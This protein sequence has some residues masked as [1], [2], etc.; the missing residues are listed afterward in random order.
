VSSFSSHAVLGMRVDSVELADAVRIVL[1]WSESVHSSSTATGRGRY[2]CAANVHM[3]MEAYDHEDFRQDVNASD[4]VV[5]DGQPVVWALRFQRVPQQRRVRVSPDWLLQVLAGAQARSLKIGLYGGDPQ[6]LRTFSERLKR[7]FPALE[8]AYAWD[9]PFRA[10]TV[11][12]EHYQAQRIREAGVQLLL[13]GLGCPKQERW[14]ARQV[15]TLP[16]VMVGVGAAFD[17]LGGRTRNAPVWMR[18]RGLE[19][20][21]RLAHEPRR[22]WR[23]H[24]FND[25]RFM[26]L[27]LGR[28][29][30]ERCARRS[31]DGAR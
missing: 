16:C 23:R 1:D 19:W 28:T 12:E 31:A 21:F 6:T 25:P 2:V 17:M 7:Y 26:A 14:M 9:P 27:L 18:D 15:D 11:E 24:V 3:T 20:V 4:L 10:L 8:V 22:L 29:L 13:V 5:P 30:F